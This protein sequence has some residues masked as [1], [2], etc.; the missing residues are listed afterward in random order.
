MICAPFFK[1]HRLARNAV[2]VILIDRKREPPRSNPATTSFM[3]S[4]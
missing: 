2:R 3:E 4:G 1:R